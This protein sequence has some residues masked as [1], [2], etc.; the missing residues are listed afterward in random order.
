MM[1]DGHNWETVTTYEPTITRGFVTIREHSYAKDRSLPLRDVQQ[2]V[3]PRGD[4]RKYLFNGFSKCG[5]DTQR[6]HSDD[7]RRFAV[8]IDSAKLR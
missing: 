2:P 8:L 1:E 6:F 4:T 5:W 7:E 3:T